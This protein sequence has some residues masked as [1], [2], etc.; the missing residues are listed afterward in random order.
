M[1]QNKSWHATYRDDSNLGLFGTITAVPY[2]IRVTDHDRKKSDSRLFDLFASSTRSATTDIGSATRDRWRSGIENAK[3]ES[4]AEIY[5]VK[6]LRVNL[7]S[8]LFSSIMRKVRVVDR[9]VRH[10]VDTWSIDAKCLKRAKHH[11]LFY[12]RIYVAHSMLWGVVAEL[13]SKATTVS[14]SRTGDSVTH[15]TDDNAD[16]IPYI[17][18]CISANLQFLLDV[19]TT[20]LLNLLCERRVSILFID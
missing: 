8:L 7:G 11:S 9:D 1:I 18:I 14:S 6:P 10:I 16:D 19:K 12:R 3:F 15:F 5:A 13:L 4:F 2:V 17:R 20:P